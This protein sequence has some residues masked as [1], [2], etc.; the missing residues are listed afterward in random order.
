MNDEE[1]STALN[2][3]TGTRINLLHFATLGSTN[4]YAKQLSQKKLLINP[5][6]IWA[7]QQTAGVGK[8]TR[9]FYSPTGGIYLSLLMPA[10]PIEPR[11]VGL[12]TTSLAMAIVSAIKQTFDLLVDVKWVNDIYFHGRKIAGILVERGAKQSV[13]IGVG[14]NL[15][16]RHFPQ[17]IQ[18]IAGN[19]LTSAPTNTEREL[20]LITLVTN[21]YRSNFTYTNSGFISDYKRRLTLMN[22]QIRVQIGHSV[23]TGKVT[24][25]NHLGQ[26]IIYDAATR[27]QRTI[28]AGEVTKILS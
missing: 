22:H 7:D 14:I 3:Q 10:L 11:K 19:L 24:D 23:V 27:K 25:I 16:E 2:N 1:I 17:E 18:Q 26:L 13:I 6:L 15:F 12:F 9:S 4:Q 8:L 21:L 20:F 5:C 28:R